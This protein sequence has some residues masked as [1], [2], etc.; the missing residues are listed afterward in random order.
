MKNENRPFG[1]TNIYDNLKGEIKKLDIIKILDELTSNNLLTWKEFGKF[2]IF[3][4]N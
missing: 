4:I 3:N 1:I 2:I